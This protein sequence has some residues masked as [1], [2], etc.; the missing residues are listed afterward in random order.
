MVTHR[1]RVTIYAQ[2]G[3]LIGTADFQWTANRI[4]H[5]G[6]IWDWRGRLRGSGTGQAGVA[7]DAAVLRLEFEDGSSRDAVYQDGDDGS[8]S[9][10][11][12]VQGQG[13]PPRVE[14]D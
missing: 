1:D 13:T 6:G 12:D 2:S 7:K 9:W 11:V 14:P 3:Q 4:G 8:R 5:P 10:W